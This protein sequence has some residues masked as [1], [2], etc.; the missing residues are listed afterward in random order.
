M[1]GSFGHL[2]KPFV[3]FSQLPA[4]LVS[5]VQLGE[6]RGVWG[7]TSV[8]AQSKGS[9][10]STAGRSRPERSGTENRLAI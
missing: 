10:A 5:G 2:T 7:S 9:A 6:S 1:T 4:A 8:G 3:W